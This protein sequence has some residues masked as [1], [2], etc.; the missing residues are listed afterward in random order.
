MNNTNIGIRVNKVDNQEKTSGSAKYIADLKFDNM[1]YGKTIRSTKARAKI[2]AIHYP[3]LPKEYFIIDHNDVPGQNRVKFLVNDQPFLAET[4][5][6]YIGE[7][8]LLIVGPNRQKLKELANKI[9]IEYQPLAAALT[10]TESLQC[11]GGAIFGTDNKFASYA[12]EKGDVSL[13]FSQAKTIETDEYT[14]GYQ[15]HAYLENQGMIA[16]PEADDK[17]TVYGSMQ[18]PYYIKRALEQALALPEEKVRIV[19]T[20][21]GG[22]FGGKEDYPS[23]LAGHAAIAA[24]K[25]GRP[26]AILY[27]RL[28]DM[29]STTRRHPAQI[30]F[31]TALDES[32]KIIGMKIDVI[33][34]GGAY[35]GISDV[36]LQRSLF[37]ITG[38]YHIQNLEVHGCVVATNTIP[39]GAFRGFGAPQAFF[40]M[41]MH[42]EMLAKKLQKNPLDYKKLHIVKQGDTTATSGLF[43]DKVPLP[44]MLE[45]IEKMS[46]YTKRYE[47]YQKNRNHHGIG[48]SLFLHGCGFTGS[49][50]RDI[51]KARI[52]LRRQ[53]NSKQVEI[54]AAN[55][56]MGQGLKTTF[57]KIVA[58]A[59]AIPMT[60][61]SF[62]N[63]DTD[64]VP[65]SGPTVA[66]RSIMIVGKLLEDAS[67]KLKARW[68]EKGAIEITQAY[69]Q[70]ERMHWDSEKSRGDAYPA[71]AWGI[72]VVEATVDPLTLQVDVNGVWTVFDIGQA[73]DEQIIQG[74]IE[75]GVL[76]GLGYANMEVMTN[77][78]SGKIMQD[79]LT[80]YTIPTMVDFGKVNHKLFTTYYNDGPFGAKGAG[81]LTL[82]GAAPAYAAAV[83]QA[84]KIHID[85]LPV[86]PEYL[87]E[88]LQ[89][90]NHFLYA[91]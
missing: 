63:P 48:I 39:N 85:R 27:D 12:Y 84:L 91:K 4:M 73:I 28:E 71:Y 8:I 36:V 18:C 1:L 19:Q 54:L 64:Q 75:G 33:L 83:A 77:D 76:Q 44:E 45:T 42:M 26:V 35:A 15:K 47:L 49:G 89:N 90:E 43:L 86:T 87:L 46:D 30:T 25:V 88:V 2:Q 41:E 34:D 80:S 3:V 51:I 70:P 38:V 53:A 52:K 78:K 6:N 58:G 5:V 57:K 22:A 79:N 13:A 31:Q 17:V 82:I 62:N 9:T 68:Q 56:D 14:T 67:R 23:I 24:K 72:N 81:E 16:V 7:P 50:E 20:T 55:V 65:D 66:S 61:I 10:Y 11:T 32:G 59:L 21:T 60:D 69:K 40:A 74:Q 37:N 29:A